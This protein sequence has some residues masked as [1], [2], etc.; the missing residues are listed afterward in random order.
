MSSGGRMMED[1]LEVVEERKRS[2]PRDTAE[3]HKNSQ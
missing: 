1:E 2:W 3:N